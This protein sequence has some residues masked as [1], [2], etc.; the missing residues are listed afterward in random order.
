MT[1]PMQK[2]VSCGECKPHTFEYFVRQK[3]KPGRRCH[4][5]NRAWAKA[6]IERKKLGTL[7]CRRC[8]ETKPHTSEFYPAKG[9]RLGRV[10]KACGPAVFYHSWRKKKEQKELNLQNY[11]KEERRPPDTELGRAIAAFL[12]SRKSL[13]EGTQ[14]SYHDTLLRYAEAFPDFPPT[15]QTVTDWISQQGLNQTSEQS[16]YGRLRT[17]ARWLHETELTPR[18]PL[19]GIVRPHTAETLPRAPKEKDIK[20]LLAYLEKRVEAAITKDPTFRSDGD[21]Y[22]DV[23]ALAMVSLMLDTGLRV[24]EVCNLDLEDVDF[25]EMSILIQ[26][27]K[28]RKQRYVIFGQKVKGDL[29]LWLKVRGE[30]SA[31]PEELQSFFVSERGKW[32]PASPGGV[33]QALKAYCKAAGVKPFTPHQ[34]RHAHA[35]YALNNGQNLEEL[36]QQMGHANLAT[37]SRYLKMPSTGRQKSHLKT[38]PLDNLAR[39]A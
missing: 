15:A 14:R 18:Y 31:L 39:A 9:D 25:D 10:C 23:R 6:G 11:Q 8:K 12:E 7:R 26:K 37:T 5:C 3:G 30:L 32:G 29:K 33:E 35:Q 20:G 2:C 4:L 28:S 21:G 38:S 24:G 16:I 36:R 27:A 1:T 13:A 34:L 19:K 22:R 17:F